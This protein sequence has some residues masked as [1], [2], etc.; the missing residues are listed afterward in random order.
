VIWQRTVRIKRHNMI[1]YIN[2][3]FKRKKRKFRMFFPWAAPAKPLRASMLYKYTVCI[4]LNVY[5]LYRA[6]PSP[7]K[8]CLQVD[9]KGKKGYNN[10]ENSAFSDQPRALPAER[11]HQMDKRLLRIRLWMVALRRL[12]L[13]LCAVTVVAVGV[14]NIEE[15]TADNLRRVA[16][17]LDVTFERGLP[18]EGYISYPESRDNRYALFKGGLSVLTPERLRIYDAAGLQFLDREMSYRQPM[19]EACRRFVL[20]YDRGGKQLNVFNSFACVFS[21]AYDGN[22]LAAR[23]NDAGYLSVLTRA[24]GYN[25]RLT[26]YDTSFREVYRRWYSEGRFASACGVSPDGAKAFVV[27]LRSD[28][29]GFKAELELLDLSQETPYATVDIGSEYPFD[30]RFLNDD[31]IAVAGDGS[32]RFY[33]AKGALISQVKFEGR[34]L[35]LYIKD[36]R[37]AAACEK[38]EGGSLSILRL[39]DARGAVLTEQRV[40]G[41]VKSVCTAGD[42]IAGLTDSALLI[43]FTGKGVR[44]LPAARTHRAVLAASGTNILLVSDGRA[45]YIEAHGK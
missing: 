38:D 32:C 10:I 35:C 7:L 34:L 8:L 3:L 26:V 31:S 43:A 4:L 44:E 23:I 36:G 2:A 15:I 17:K 5:R 22:I 6:F 21:A 19:V 33:D 27:V 28:L 29:K 30:A 45:E 37:V 24:K 1:T 18:L 13:I 16:A 39:M 11:V 40:Q 25:V 20:T 14:I 42:Y 9:A 41:V 12:C